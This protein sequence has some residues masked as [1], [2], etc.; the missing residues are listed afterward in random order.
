[1]VVRQL[2]VKLP[3]PPDPNCPLQYFTFKRLVL[4][5]EGWESHVW[6]TGWRWGCESKHTVG[7]MGEGEGEGGG[8][9]ACMYVRMCMREC[10]YVHMDGSVHVFVCVHMYTRVVHSMC[11]CV[12]VCV[13]TC[14]RGRKERGKGTVRAAGPRSPSAPHS[15]WLLVP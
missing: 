12:Y 10:V 4:Q 7:E 9:S 3:R 14:G 6:R 11:T 13:R 5:R 15:S 1:M 8:D 2:Q